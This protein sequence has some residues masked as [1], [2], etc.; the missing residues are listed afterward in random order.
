MRLGF[1]TL[2]C[3]GEPIERVLELATTTGWSGVELRAAD[4]EPVNVGVDLAERRRLRQLFAAR[5]VTA[6]AIASYIC[7]A[8]RTV[9]DDDV[10]GAL[11]DH[12]RLA[13]DLGAAHVRVFPGSDST[14]PRRDDD[15]AVGR[16]RAVAASLGTVDDGVTI[17]VETHDSHPRG[18]DVARLL[19]RV[20]DPRIRAIWDVLH[21]W[22]TGESVDETVAALGDR[23]AYVQIKDV[24]STDVLAP[25]PPGHGVLPLAAVADALDEQ[26]YDGWVSLE[27]E[28]KWFPDAL[29]LE[30]AIAESTPMGRLFHAT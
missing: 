9:D 2:G 29:P 12:V 24:A 27:W 20:D 17:A 22:R 13:A 11:I 25:L 30:V 4:D 21:P 23:L 26:G 19:D 3:S 8:D 1:S 28:A 16:L 15:I 18:T 5:D 14:D 10:V 6:L 7:I